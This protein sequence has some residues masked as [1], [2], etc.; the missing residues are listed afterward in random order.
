M[1][2]KPNFFLDLDQTIISGEP[3]EEY[4]FRKYNDKAKRF[5]FKSMEKLDGSTVEYV[6]SLQKAGF[7]ITNPNAKKSCGCGSS[8]S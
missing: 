3:T 4:D 5:D 1:T 6:D 7:K 8:F 2:E